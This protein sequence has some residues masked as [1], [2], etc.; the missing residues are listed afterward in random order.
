MLEIFVLKVSEVTGISSSGLGDSVVT[1][2]G[3]KLNSETP[4]SGTETG[5]LAVKV[6]ACGW[7]EVTVTGLGRLVGRMPMMSAAGQPSSA[8]SSCLI[9]SA[10]QLTGYLTYIHLSSVGPLNRD[11][12]V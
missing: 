6:H 5:G 7:A 4:S 10:C 1:I 9:A 11:W 8:T 12:I 3:A 2:T